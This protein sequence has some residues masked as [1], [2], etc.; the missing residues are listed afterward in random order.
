MTANLD[1]QVKLSEIENGY[2]VVYGSH[3]VKFS[4]FV[5]ALDEFNSCVKHSA[6]CASLLDDDDEYYQD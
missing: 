6:A 3:G 2:E 5:Q 4:S 1:V